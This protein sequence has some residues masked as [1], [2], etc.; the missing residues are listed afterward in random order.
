M[1]SRSFPK[2]FNLGSPQTVDLFKEP[3]EITEKIDGSQFGFGLIDGKLIT[4][5]KGREFDVPD[6]MFQT[7][8]DVVQS[9]KHLLPSEIMY[10]GEYL[11]KPKHNILAYKVTPPNYIALFGAYD[12][13]ANSW[14]SFESLTAHAHLINLTC[15]QRIFQGHFANPE[16]IIDLIKDW[17]SQLGGPIEGVVIKNYHRKAEFAGKELDLLCGKFVREE[18]KETHKL[19]WKRDHTSSG[20]LEA[21]KASYRSEARW[22]KAIQHLRDS[23]ELRHDLPDIG[24]LIKEIGRDIKEECSKTIENQLYKIFIDDILRNA[25]RGFPEWYKEFLIKDRYEFVE[26]M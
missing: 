23:G 24:P 7:A 19:E 14:L 12:V 2:I 4:R 1:Y 16:S 9:I 20:G 11:N 18:F 6:K 26:E 15:V 3:V 21:L 5:S 22:H 25:T 10:Y 13:Y 8:F 17:E